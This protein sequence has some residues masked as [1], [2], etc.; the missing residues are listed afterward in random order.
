M[1]WLHSQ[2]ILKVKGFLSGYLEDFPAWSLQRKYRIQHTT[3]TQEQLYLQTA[4]DEEE[5]NIIWALYI[6]RLYTKIDRLKDK[7]KQL[8]FSCLFHWK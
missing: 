4:Y 8:L 6:W 5:R 1:L 7:A 2:F 3:S